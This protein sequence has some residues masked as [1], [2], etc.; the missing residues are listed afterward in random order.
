[1]LKRTLFVTLG[2]IFLFV[3]W[4]IGLWA[5]LWSPVAV[6]LSHPSDSPVVQLWILVALPLAAWTVCGWI[7]TRVDIGRA[8]RDLAPLFA[9]VVLLLHLVLTIP[10][11]TV[12]LAEVH[13]NPVGPGGAAM[14]TAA[15]DII[16]ATAVNIAVSVF[17]ILLGGRLRWTSGAGMTALASRR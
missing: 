8:H 17:G 3:L 15:A 14:S 16:V 10:G 7:V 11:L 12:F 5:A 1:M 2:L 9:G 4:R 13:G 6:S